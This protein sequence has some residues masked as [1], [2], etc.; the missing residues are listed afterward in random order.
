MQVTNM[1]AVYYQELQLK[2]EDK[3]IRKGMIIYG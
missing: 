1:E 3:D 2:I